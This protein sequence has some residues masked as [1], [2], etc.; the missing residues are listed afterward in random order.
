MGR[1]MNRAARTRSIG[2]PALV[3]LTACATLAACAGGEAVAPAVTGVPETVA[4]GGMPG[5]LSDTTAPTLPPVESPTSTTTTTEPPA[6]PVSPPLV[7]D[8]L[9]HR[10]LLVGDTGLSVTTTRAEG[11]LCDVVTGFGWDVEI[12]AE[13]GRTIAFA[14]VVLD[15][16]LDRSPGGDW[17]VVGLMF[18]HHVDTTVDDFEQSL[19]AVLD[20][21]S[22]RPV[23]LYTVAGTDAEQQQI[24]E[25]LRAR[26]DTYPNVVVI[27][28]A[29]A[30]AGEPDVLLED[31]GPFPSEDGAGRLAVFTAG[32]LSDVPGD[33]VGTCLESVFT[34]DSAIV[35]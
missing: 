23:I 5:P 16:L 4:I 28:W 11:I 35:L 18:G 17:D 27:D 21:L 1:N 33:A 20:R 22:P 10:V 32:L 8:V 19:D 24:N 30:V 29:D 15:E 31:G 6:E 14:D 3:A 26:P 12:E 25:V 2:A 9:G 13:P 7:D 34:D